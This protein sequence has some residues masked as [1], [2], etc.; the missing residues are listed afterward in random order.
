MLFFGI[1]IVVFLKKTKTDGSMR[2]KYDERQQLVRGRGFKYAFFTMLLYDFFL[3]L[4]DCMD[5]RYGDMGTEMGTGM[6]LGCAVYAIYC[7]LNDGYFSMNE[8]MPRVLFVLISLGLVNLILGIHSII[9]GD[10][11]E[12]GMLTIQ[13][14]NLLCGLIMLFILTVA[15]IKHIRSK[16]EEE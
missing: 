10:I 8:N 14:M 5:I 1:A 16:N 6:M 2:C 11:V 7:I 13:S 12:D 9:R 3:V 4:L 15:A